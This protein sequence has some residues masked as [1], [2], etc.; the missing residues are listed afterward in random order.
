MRLVH[1]FAAAPITCHTGHLLLVSDV[2]SLSGCPETT[3]PVQF[4]LHGLHPV[5]VHLQQ[6]L[7]VLDSLN[8]PPG[9]VGGRLPLICAL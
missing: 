7:I 8:G 2:E 6:D 4:K 5:L 9:K 3:Q 1:L